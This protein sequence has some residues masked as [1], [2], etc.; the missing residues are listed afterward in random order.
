M[1]RIYTPPRLPRTSSCSSPTPEGSSA[2]GGHQPSYAPRRAVLPWASRDKSTSLASSTWVRHVSKVP[3]PRGTIHARTSP[4]LSDPGDWSGPGFPTCQACLC[5]SRRTLAH[6]V[7]RAGVNLSSADA[8]TSSLARRTRLNGGRARIDARDGALQPAVSMA[9]LLEQID[10][11]PPPGY[12]A[13][14]SR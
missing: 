4:T 13:Q 14:A 9:R 7:A 2:I 5:L 1:R 11:V 6:C 3:H 12:L 8:W 10:D